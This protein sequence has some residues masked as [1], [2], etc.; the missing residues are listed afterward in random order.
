LPFVL[1]ANALG[2]DRLIPLLLLATV[3]LLREPPVRFSGKGA[4]FC[5]LRRGGGLL[6]LERCCEAGTDWWET[7]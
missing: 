2:D 3:L 7:A 1:R 5:R 4:R 6:E